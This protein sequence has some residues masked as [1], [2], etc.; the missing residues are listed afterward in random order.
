MS[1]VTRT[2][3]GIYYPESRRVVDALWSERPHAWY[4]QNYT[5]RQDA[6][7]RPFLDRWRAWV[8]EAGVTLGAGFAH[9]YPTAGANEAIHA[10]LAQLAVAARGER[11]RVHVFDGEYEGYTHLAAALGLEVVTHRRSEEAY[12]VSLAERGRAGDQFWISQPS[13]I[14]GNLWSGF[15]G[16]RRAAVETVP[17]LD[18]VVDLTY[19]GAVALA[20]R[21]DLDHEAVA[22]VVWSLSKPFGVYYHRVGGV[23]TRAEVATLRGHHW[24][25]NLFSVHLGERLMAAHPARELPARY[26][27]VQE[28]VLAKARASGQV[29]PT[30]EV[31]DVVMLAHAPAAGAPRTDAFKEYAR[32]GGLRF[33]LSPAM[34]RSIQ[35]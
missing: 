17:G 12:R 18:L 31:S 34:D 27:P 9:G 14:D 16:F 13:A 29:A 2:V 26:K 4:E 8:T 19:V 11:R 6:M 23:V 20:P 10:L 24:F 22:A 7:H 3:Y 15:D 5:G 30:A 25:K 21:V 28:A 1:D 33:C 35:P 32:A